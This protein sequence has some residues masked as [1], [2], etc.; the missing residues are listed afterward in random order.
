M[1]EVGWQQRMLQGLESAY[2][3]GDNPVTVFF[4]LDFVAKHHLTIPPWVADYVSASAQN[5]HTVA[6][7]NQ[8]GK[9]A[10]SAR[11]DRGAMKG[12]ETEEI[13][14]AL[15][16]GP[17]RRG[18]TAAAKEAQEIQRNLFLA[19]HVALQMGLD[20]E[21]GRP[22]KLDGIAAMVGERQRCSVSTVKRAYAAYRDHAEAAL[23]A[24]V[25]AVGQE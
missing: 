15:G 6:Q 2:R 24:A 7:R 18:G 19:L 11:K 5:I 1:R 16:F 14:R 4:A 8:K 21:K 12:N 20:E 13:G 25:E 23:R 10:R 3:E 22:S 9:R 17:S